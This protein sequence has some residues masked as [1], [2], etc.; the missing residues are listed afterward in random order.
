MGLKLFCK[1]K[2]AAVFIAISITVITLLRESQPVH[3]LGQ[4]HV[5]PETGWGATELKLSSKGESAGI[6]Y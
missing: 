2:R 6:D 5:I 1:V 4:F 3:P